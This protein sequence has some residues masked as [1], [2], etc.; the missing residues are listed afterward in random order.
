VFIEASS[1]CLVEPPIGLNDPALDRLQTRSLDNRS[2]DFDFV[3]RAAFR[4]HNNDKCALW[5]LAHHEVWRHMPL[6]I[7]TG[8]AAPGA[9]GSILIASSARI[10]RAGAQHTREC[11]TRTARIFDRAVEQG[12]PL[13]VPRASGSQFVIV[14]ESTNRPIF[15]VALHQGARSEEPGT[16]IAELSGRVSGARRMI[17]ASVSETTGRG[18]GW[19]SSR[20]RCGRASL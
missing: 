14:D 20:P 11:L 6:R 1:P 8:R 19:V 17:F 13:W 10:Y 12:F 2:R 16:S 4:I 18:A 5:H 7:L 9:Y 15:A 3:P